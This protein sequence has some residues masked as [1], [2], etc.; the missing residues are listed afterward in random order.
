MLSEAA[1]GHCDSWWR[2]LPYS[3]TSLPRQQYQRRLVS[4]SPRPLEAHLP[5]VIGQ[6]DAEA[7]CASTSSA[8]QRLSRPVGHSFRCPRRQPA[9]RFGQAFQS[10]TQPVPGLAPRQGA[11]HGSGKGLRRSKAVCGRIEPPAHHGYR[12]QVSRFLAWR[13][14]YSAA[15][16]PSEATPAAT[17]NANL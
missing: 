16:T 6:P 14:K 2:L 15:T 17:K 13:K 11:N 4:L 7:G 1:R 3:S 5:C 8:N 10:V 9:W 12:H